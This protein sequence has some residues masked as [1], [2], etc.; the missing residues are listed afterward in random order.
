[1]NQILRK[2][3]SLFKL[4]WL[5]S[6]VQ[7]GKELY[8]LDRIASKKRGR[9]PVSEKENRD[10]RRL[11]AVQAEYDDLRSIDIEELK[12]LLST[13]PTVWYLVLVR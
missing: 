3:S 7:L 4:L 8:I 1:M 5:C 6:Q 9:L 13:V 11:P 10:V 12:V 2:P